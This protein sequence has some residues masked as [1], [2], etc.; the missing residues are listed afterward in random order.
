MSH[1]LPC[2]SNSL[3]PETKGLYTQ[4]RLRTQTLFLLYIELVVAEFIDIVTSCKFLVLIVAVIKS[5]IVCISRKEPVLKLIPAIDLNAAFQLAAS[6]IQAQ[7]AWQ[8]S[9]RGA[10]LRYD[11]SV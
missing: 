4:H 1:R 9:Y 10:L 2:L 3:K 6:V 11:I 7:I 8:A 5:Q